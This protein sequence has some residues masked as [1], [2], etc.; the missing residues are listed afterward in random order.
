MVV[1][2]VNILALP[3]SSF[4]IKPFPVSVFIENSESQTSFTWQRVFLRAD[5][6]QTNSLSKQKSNQGK[7]CSGGV[8]RQYANILVNRPSTQQ[9]PCVSGRGQ[10]TA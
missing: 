1:C 8:D 3:P 9:Q 10:H 7:R 2:F 4:V 5:T 6:R